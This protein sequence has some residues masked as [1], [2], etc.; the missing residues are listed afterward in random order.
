[1][2]IVRKIVVFNRMITPRGHSPTKNSALRRAEPTPS[3][4]KYQN[5]LKMQQIHQQARHH[6]QMNTSIITNPKYQTAVSSRQDMQSQK[7]LERTV[8][9]S[10]PLISSPTVPKSAPT[11]TAAKSNAVTSTPKGENT[12]TSNPTQ[13]S[14]V[15]EPPVAPHIVINAA[16]LKKKSVRWFN[17]SATFWALAVMDAQRTVDCP[18]LSNFLEAMQWRACGKVTDSEFTAMY[19]EWI[20]GTG[21]TVLASSKRRGVIGVFATRQL[22]LERKCEEHDLDL[23][24][25]MLIHE[26]NKALSGTALT[27]ST[28]SSKS[29]PIIAVSSSSHKR[30]AVLEVV[31]PRWLTLAEELFFILDTPGFG[32]VR[33]DEVYVLAACLTMGL[34][35]W[36]TQSELEADCSLGIL[37]ASALQMMKEMGCSVTTTGLGQELLSLGIS[38]DETDTRERSTVH[39]LDETALDVVPLSDATMLSGR[40]LSPGRASVSGRMVAVPN[41]GKFSITVPMFKSWLISKSV[42][43][44]ALADLVAHVRACVERLGR[45]CVQSAASSAAMSKS[46]TGGLS[47]ETP[48]SQRLWHCAVMRAGGSSWAPHDGSHNSSQTPPILLYLLSDAEKHIPGCLRTAEESDIDE[49]HS[50][51]R[52]N[53]RKLAPQRKVLDSADELLETVSR[54]HAAYSTWGQ[55]NNHVHSARGHQ[56]LNAT[57]RS[58][59]SSSTALA[60]GDN[61]QHNDRD[62]VYRLILSSLRTYKSLQD[63]F[64]S[65]VMTTAAVH[66]GHGHGPS[67]TRN[68]V[69]ARVCLGLLPSIE[70]MLVDLGLCEDPQTEPEPEP[71]QSTPSVPHKHDLIHQSQHSAHNAHGDD[72]SHH[73]HAS[74]FAAYQP[75]AE[76]ASSSQHKMPDKGVA[77]SDQPQPLLQRKLKGGPQMH[78]QQPQPQSSQLPQAPI[79]EQQLAKPNRHQPPASHDETNH[80]NV[81]QHPVHVHSSAP[82]AVSSSQSATPTQVLSPTEAHLLAS[83]LTAEDPLLQASI[84]SLLRQLRTQNSDRIHTESLG[85]SGPSGHRVTDNEEEDEEEDDED[86]LT[87]LSY[88][89]VA[90][91]ANARG[92]QSS[93][94][95]VRSSIRDH[96]QAHHLS[97]RPQPTSR[98]SSAPAPIP[99][100]SM[101]QNQSRS[102]TPSIRAHSDDSEYDD[103]VTEEGSQQQ[104]SVESVPEPFS[105]LEDLLENGHGAGKHAQTL[106]GLLRQMNRDDAKVRRD[107]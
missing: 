104:T 5:F 15:S 10:T 55:A 21:A 76:G 86:A 44:A 18:S 82:A 87:G 78:S 47:P 8:A 66:L 37:G 96:D 90:K 57:G 2:L 65:L 48:I 81:H 102:S 92:K 24:I 70:G 28:T 67:T 7:Q 12:V 106:R 32:V 36:T 83:L 42:G 97:K 58:Q 77:W 101:P 71:I 62:P 41:F 93:S 75:H 46:G 49:S 25:G 40:V 51:L 4:Q 27:Y 94:A 17:Q 68:S 30:H 26:A 105:S 1:M 38:R 52:Q 89:P 22:L 20:S 34:Q 91:E 53:S 50:L 63:H 107:R 80:S 99:T 73:G 43:E 103:S 56:Y 84:I 100:V 3:Q 33:Y 13:A 9:P 39:L 88:G 95:P 54:M 72:G 64:S 69:L 23:L 29:S 19:I 31:T 85:K 16:L 61:Y 11:I 45:L 35:N 59:P 14:A 79:V 6:Q 98:Q 60:H 74:A